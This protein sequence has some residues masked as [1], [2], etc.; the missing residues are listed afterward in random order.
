MRRRVGRGSGPAV[1]YLPGPRS[2]GPRRDRTCVAMSPAARRRGPPFSHYGCG[3]AGPLTP[4]RLP[5][6]ASNMRQGKRWKRWAVTRISFD[7]SGFA[8]AAKTEI[9]KVLTFIVFIKRGKTASTDRASLEVVLALKTDTARSNSIICRPVMSTLTRT[10]TVSQLPH[11]DINCVTVA[12]YKRNHYLLYPIWHRQVE[13]VLC[14]CDL[15]TTVIDGTVSHATLP[16]LRALPCK[17]QPVPSLTVKERVQNGN[18]QHPALCY[19]LSLVQLNHNTPLDQDLIQLDHVRFAHFSGGFLI[20]S[21]TNAVFYVCCRANRT[22]S[23]RCE[24][25]V[26]Y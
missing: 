1:E 17:L 22:A 18:Q 6:C 26:F 2:A 25:C 5:V 10:S 8:S 7:F 13:K 24:N 21:S 9:P 14:S 4:Q 16:S 19:E 23:L 3:R 20:L 15:S 12:S 11:K